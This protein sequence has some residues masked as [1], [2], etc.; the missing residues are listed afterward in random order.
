[1]VLGYAVFKLGQQLHPSGFSRYGLTI[2]VLGKIKWFISEPVQNAFS[3]Y[4]VPAK[5]HL[6]VWVAITIVVGAA[7]AH[8]RP[9]SGSLLFT[10]AAAL[11]CLIGSYAPN[12]VSA[13]NWASYRS[14]G[15]LGASVLVLFVMSFRQPYLYFKEAF[16]LLFINSRANPYLPVLPALALVALT[17]FTQSNVLNGLVLPNVAELD[18]VASVLADAEHQGSLAGNIS[19]K[20]S[21][22]ADSAARPRIYDEFG[23]QSSFNEP[24]ARAIVEIVLRETN[25]RAGAVVG[26]ASPAGASQP[27]ENRSTLLI[28][29]PRLASSQKFR[30]FATTPLNAG[31]G[32]IFPLDITDDNWTKGIWSNK[33]HPGYSFV[34]RAGY[35]DPQLRTGDQLRFRRSGVRS[36]LRVDVSGDFVNVLVDG[37]PL[38]PEDGHP[39]PVARIA[40]PR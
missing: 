16:G 24:Y 26:Y 17:A 33:G 32:A 37:P 25:S 20:P 1:M 30:G 12:L 13:E 40:T 22:W 39:E 19:I 36:V 15:A 10:T 34:Y 29:F 28:D 9:R 2:D 7:F 23:I 8:L 6:G 11:F 14:T 27:P 21:S 31:P 3:L 5:H 18:N 4:A 38:S 35:G